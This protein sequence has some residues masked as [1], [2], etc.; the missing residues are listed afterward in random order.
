MHSQ[1]INIKKN[2][3][4]GLSDSLYIGNA[5]KLLILNTNSSFIYESTKETECVS[6]C[7]D[8]TSHEEVPLPTSLTDGS[9]VVIVTVCNEMYK[10]TFAIQ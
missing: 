9:Y 10:G 6:F 3:T 7:I 2:Q 5:G 4:I 8:I 1:W